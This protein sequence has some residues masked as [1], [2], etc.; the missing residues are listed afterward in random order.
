[1][2][3][4]SAAGSQPIDERREN[5]SSCAAQ[6]CTH[7]NNGFRQSLGSPNCLMSSCVNYHQRF[8][9][10]AR[11]APA[12]ALVTTP[13]ANLR[14]ASAGTGWPQARQ[15]PHMQV[16]IGGCLGAEHPPEQKAG[17]HCAAPA[18][19]LEAIAHSLL[20]DKKPAMTQHN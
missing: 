6:S 8:E 10:G 13:L 12:F 17:V 5:C 1:M 2:L 4:R 14:A 18:A 19:D 20:P 11:A 9:T 16:A 3:P 15:P 7:S